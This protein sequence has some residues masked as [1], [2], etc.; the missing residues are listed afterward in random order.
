M[1]KIEKKDKVL[2]IS[3]LP[4]KETGGGENYTRNCAIAISN[5]GVECHLASPT[6]F[7]FIHTRNRSRFERL[8][9]KTIFI[10][11]QSLH[12]L[13]KESFIE[14]LS[15]ISEYKYVWIHQHLATPLVY[16][17]LLASDP[18][19]IILFTNLGFEENAEDFWIRY[20]RVPNH[21]FIEISQYSASRTQKYTHNVSYVYG[22]AW[23]KKL[24]ESFSKVL[25]KKQQF[26]SVGRLLPH[27]A[28]EVAIDALS[29][30]SSLLIIG[31]ESEEKHYKQFLQNKIK[32]RKIDIVG[33]ISSSDRD[34]ITSRSLALIANSSSVTYDNR[35]FEQ[36]E[37]LGLVLIEAILNNTL[38]IA[39]SQPA[40]KEVMTVLEMEELVYPERESQSL[41]SKML[42]VKSLSSD[43][44]QELINKAKKNIESLFLWDNYWTRVQNLIDEKMFTGE[45]YAR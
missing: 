43:E 12:S 32:G 27:K 8:F 26:V 45:R 22:G 44:Y 20:N 33:E 13:V 38:P 17:I 19:Q 42:F 11:E 41:K 14:I 21:L 7:A 30:N 40:L 9:N 18:E 24:E 23:K 34:N 39:S 3:L 35:L 31:P 6:E 1:V 4:L 10:G 29:G 2:V 16:D 15:T 25:P 36:S 5:L 28:F 37:L